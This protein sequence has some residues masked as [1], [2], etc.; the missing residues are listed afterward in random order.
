[1]PISSIGSLGGME[2]TPE[3]AASYAGHEGLLRYRAKH[4][5]HCYERFDSV[6]LC[7]LSLLEPT[8]CKKALENYRP[9]AQE[10]RKRKLSKLEEAEARRRAALTEKSK[11]LEAAAGGGK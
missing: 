1:M 7:W 10:M 2:V 3:L 11:E 5:P 6:R 4:P 9:C 8:A